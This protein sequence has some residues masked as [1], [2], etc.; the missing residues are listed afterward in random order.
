MIRM[1][2]FDMGALHTNCYL[3][4]NSKEAVVFD[5]P[6]DPK[7]LLDFMAE[8]GLA[9]TH[10]FNTHLHFDHVMGNA[11]LS[12]AT[13]IPV[14]AN[15]KD[16]YLTSPEMG[17]ERFGLPPTPPFTYENLDAG[18][19]PVLGATCK[20][21]ATPGHTPGSLSYYFE[22]PGWL[23]VGDVLFYRSMGRTDLP[24]G[25]AQTLFD[26]IRNVLF[27]LPAETEVHPGHGIPTTIGD[28][29]S[30]N[31]YVGKALKR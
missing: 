19:V 17:G 24:G 5:V 23:F 6:A 3:V 1:R 26:S 4:H 21:L 18:E 12:R 29:A 13:G 16:D 28:E 11:A 2:I 31:P 30:N 14:F 9:L 22:E 20:V 27:A 15:K 8:E 7:P 10:I 25:E